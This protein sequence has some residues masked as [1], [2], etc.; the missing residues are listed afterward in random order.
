M[1]KFRRLQYTGYVGRME[2]TVC[3]DI[4]LGGLLKNEDAY[5]GI[6]LRRI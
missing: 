2:E 6:I 1:V 5:E 3:T 4:R